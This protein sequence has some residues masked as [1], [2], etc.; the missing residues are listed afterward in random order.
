LF[1]KSCRA[2]RKATTPI[3]QVPKA[4]DTRHG[5]IGYWKRFDE[6]CL[7]TV[8]GF[9]LHLQSAFR[10]HYTTAVT[11]FCLGAITIS[12]LAGIVIFHGR[13]EWMRVPATVIWVSMIGFLVHRFRITYWRDR[14]YWNE[15]CERYWSSF[16]TGLRRRT[17]GWRPMLLIVYA[18]CALPRPAVR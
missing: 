1:W 2:R 9:V 15:E 6:F 16:A 13:F 18:M 10:I 8:D 4:D 12:A 5:M 3:F 7:E 14:K 11:A 17:A